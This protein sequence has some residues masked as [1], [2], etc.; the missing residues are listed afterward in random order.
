MIKL[1]L[2]QYKKIVYSKKC[3][4]MAWSENYGAHAVL[5]RY[6]RLKWD[7]NNSNSYYLL[8]HGVFF[9]WHNETCEILSCN[10][11]NKY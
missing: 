10:I 1:Q 8:H 5:E 3:G 6:V 7:L 11:L 4:K 2:P 9:P